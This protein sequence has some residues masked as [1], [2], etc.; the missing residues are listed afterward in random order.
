MLVV[1]DNADAA[2]SLARVLETWGHAVRIATDGPTA[3]AEIEAE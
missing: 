3:L 2:D 1:E